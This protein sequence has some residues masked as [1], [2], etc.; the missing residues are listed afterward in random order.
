ML[1]LKLQYFDHLMRTTDSLEKT[2][3][4]EKIEGRRRRGRQRI[5]WLDGITDSMD[6]SLSKLWELVKDREAWC[7]A[8]HGVS[9]SRT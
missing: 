1:R 2:L 5:R 9:K 4:L 7:A 6:M 8:V 3:I